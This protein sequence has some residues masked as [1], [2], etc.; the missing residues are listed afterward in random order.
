MTAS[1]GNLW[2][3]I[4]HNPVGNSSMGTNNLLAAGLTGWG[5]VLQE[6]ANRS[7]YDAYIR[8]AES[9]VSTA[10][11]NAK[12]IRDQ[13]ARALLSLEE[14]NK[15]VIGSDV[16]KLSARGT[17]G[18]KMS[19]SNIDVLLSKMK[20]QATNE[21]ILQNSTVQAAS[22]EIINGYRRAASAYSSLE[23]R[24]AADKYGALLGILQATGQYVALQSRDAFE[25]RKLDAQERAYD[26]ELRRVEE[27]TKLKKGRF[28]ESNFAATDISSNNV[29]S[30]RDEIQ[31]QTGGSD[32]DFFRIGDTNG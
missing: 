29:L 3:Y 11:E 27:S 9:Y 19:G 30:L 14:R 32:L 6:Q 26:Q 25:I 2:D 10:L 21:A 23:G 1:F 8:Q 18:T 20:A 24:A 13:G 15:Q 7:S 17:A 22:N 16:A 12:L 28:F 4:V 31:Q 5:N